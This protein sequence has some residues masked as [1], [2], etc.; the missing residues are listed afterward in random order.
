MKLPHGCRF[1]RRCPQ[2]MARC[3]EVEPPLRAADSGRVVACHLYH[4]ADQ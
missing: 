2:A 3:T 1:H 4:L